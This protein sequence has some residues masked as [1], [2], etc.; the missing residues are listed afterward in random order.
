MKIP[1][2]PFVTKMFSSL[3]NHSLGYSGRKVT[4]AFSVLIGA[5]ITIYEL[6]KDTLLHALYSWQIVAL[7]CLGIVTV[8][9]IIAFKNGNNSTTTKESTSTE[10]TS[11]TVT[12]KEQTA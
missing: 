5:Y 12:S 4:A 7:L 10:T 8:E 3:D 6:P 1:K 2:I 9:N 11:E